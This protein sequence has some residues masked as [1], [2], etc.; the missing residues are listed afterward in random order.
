MSY[1]IIFFTCF[2]YNHIVFLLLGSWYGKNLFLEFFCA[3]FNA[4]NDL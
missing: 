1:K 3:I 4:S 2:Y